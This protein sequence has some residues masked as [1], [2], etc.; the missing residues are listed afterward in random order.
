MEYQ[1]PDDL[2]QRYETID[3]G[4][5]L[6]SEIRLCRLIAERMA[7]GPGLPHAAQVASVIGRLAERDRSMKIE[8]RGLIGIGQ[9]T[10]LMQWMSSLYVSVARR[11]L[12]I[13][14]AAELTD[15][16]TREFL[17]GFHQFRSTGK[18]P[19]VIDT[20]QPLTIEVQSDR[21]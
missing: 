5:D 20:T 3:G 4:A 15:D 13:D 21:P 12:P 1:L 9:L 2:K 17:L 10:Q 6:S 16:F 14:R 19:A 8:E 18:I 7:S 11:H